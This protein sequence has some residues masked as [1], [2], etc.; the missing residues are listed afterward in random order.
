M[1]PPPPLVALGCVRV[2]LDGFLAVLDGCI[3]SL[4]LDERTVKKIIIAQDTE[5]TV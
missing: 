5:N 1:C 2:E 4:Q 3:R